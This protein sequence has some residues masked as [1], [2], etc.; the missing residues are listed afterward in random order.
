MLEAKV[1]DTELEMESRLA[2]RA[3]VARSVRMFDLFMGFSQNV[4]TICGFS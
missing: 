4:V 3:C 2:A 1:Y